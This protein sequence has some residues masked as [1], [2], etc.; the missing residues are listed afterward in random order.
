MFLKSCYNHKT[1]RRES[2][3]ISGNYLRYLAKT[4]TTN[5]KNVQLFMYLHS[6]VV[7]H[8]LLNLWQIAKK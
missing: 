3:K 4:T 6:Y 8:L 5:Q 1:V 7:S 2:N